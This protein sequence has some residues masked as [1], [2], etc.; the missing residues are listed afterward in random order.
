[1]LVLSAVAVGLYA[2]V[3]LAERLLIPWQEATHV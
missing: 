1:V 3:S 2:L